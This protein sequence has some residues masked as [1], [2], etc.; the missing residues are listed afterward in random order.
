MNLINKVKESKIVNWIYK[1]FSKIK[2]EKLKIVAWMDN[3][4]S[5]ERPLGTMWNL[6]NLLFGIILIGACM[7]C[8]FV[9]PFNRF[10]K[11]VGIF[12]IAYLIKTIVFHIIYAIYYETNKR[13]K[14]K[15]I[16]CITTFIITTVVIWFKI[17]FFNSEVIETTG[18]MYL[19]MVI[20]DVLAVKNFDKDILK[21]IKYEK[22]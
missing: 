10:G 12:T 4:F 11:Y 19:S 1:L 15:F 14:P 5:K 9:A 6:K 7:Q 3:L 16:Y 18:L 2:G 21:Y 13:S 8:Y 22:S 20:F 17:K